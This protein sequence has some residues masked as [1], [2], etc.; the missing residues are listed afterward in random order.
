MG[1]IGEQGE[2][3]LDNQRIEGNIQEMMFL[4]VSATFR[5]VAIRFLHNVQGIL[6]RN[7]LA[8]AHTLIFRNS[9]LIGFKIQRIQRKG[10]FV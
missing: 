10:Q 8:G 3:F 1:E 4:Q 9:G 6:K 7:G 5:V 2:R